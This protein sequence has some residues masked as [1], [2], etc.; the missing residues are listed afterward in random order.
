M[1]DATHPITQSALRAF[2]REYLAGL[3]ASLREDGNRWRVRLPSHVDVGFSDDREFEVVLGDERRDDTDESHLLTPDSEFAQQLLAEAS[4]MARVGRLALTEDH[5]AGDYRYPAWITAGSA[6][7]ADATFHPYYDRTGVCAFVRIGVETVSEYQ[8]QFLRAVAVDAES[9]TRL[10]GIAERLVTEFYAPKSEPAADRTT[11][12]DDAT[13]SP[14]GLADAIAAGQRTATETV[15]S[16]I[17]EVRRSATRA[18]DSEFEEYRQLREQRLDELRD[19]IDSVSNRLQTIAAEAD[20]AESRQRRVEI[21][22]KRRELKD[23][24]ADVEAELEK[25][26]REKERGYAEKRREIYDR[27]ALDVTTTP[28]AVTLVTYERGEIDLRLREGVEPSRSA[29]PTQSARE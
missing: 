23:R 1:T 14:D 2:A 9:E 18:A 11:E 12:T 16:E 15:R 22:E 5:L 28:L 3:G 24:K 25:V 10:P 26:C 19:E 21:L 20:D 7:V 17:E 4:E 13:I 29:S 8:T 6:E 27:H